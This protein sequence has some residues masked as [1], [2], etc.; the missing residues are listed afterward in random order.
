MTL[1]AISYGG[2]VQ[3][4][5]L[6]ILAATRNPRF[7]EAMGGR[8]DGAVFAN[9]GD[10]SEDPRALRW[11][12]DV[13]TPWA[14]ALGFR[15]DTVRR[16]K[17]D[18]TTPTLLEDHGDPSSRSINIPLR[19]ANGAPG[20]RNCS[21]QWKIRPVANWLKAN[22]A[23]KDDPALVAIGFST[24]EVERVTR[25]R[26]TRY[27]RSVFPLLDLGMDR[28][29][30]QRLNVDTFGEAAPKSACWFC[31]YKRPAAFAE[32]RRDD[33]D[34]FAAAVEVERTAN[35]TRDR[36]GKDHVYLTRFGKPLDEAV[37]EAQTP[38]FTD[39]TWTDPGEAGCDSGHC[40]T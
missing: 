5:A 37:G 24:D 7:E 16:T 21:E 39:E 6:V 14:A 22:G 20:N 15:V 4:T 33:P 36:I 12:R 26:D 10:D 3:S 19:M 29:A 8:V 9:V 40:F 35:R 28:S 1:R 34:T 18:G 31:P 17:R 38:L 25:G 11:V 32:M 23:T 30:C 13:V 27:Q 2:G